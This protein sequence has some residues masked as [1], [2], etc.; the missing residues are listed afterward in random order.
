MTRKRVAAVVNLALL[1]SL[2]WIIVSPS[3]G[4][5][6][7][8]TVAV[9]GPACSLSLAI[10]PRSVTATVA[11]CTNGVYAL[12][13]WSAQSAVLGT[14]HPQ[15]LF[16]RVTG[17][18]WTVA[19]PPC[20]WQVDFSELSPDHHFLAAHLGGQPCAPTTTSTT[21]PA[22]STTATTRPL[23]QATPRC[24]GQTGTGLLA[25]STRWCERSVGFWTA[26]GK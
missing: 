15:A 13:S 21:G 23:S 16:R 2:I 7:T 1:A 25:G 19:L 11:G 9:D 17:P 20:F 4:R 5:Q 8:T 22:V 18:P 3:V 12:S 10:G 26:T 14:S 6:A 24:P